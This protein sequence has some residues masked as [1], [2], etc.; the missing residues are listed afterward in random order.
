MDYQILPLDVSG[1]QTTQPSCQLHQDRKCD[2][3]HNT[4]VLYVGLLSTIPYQ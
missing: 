3:V 2:F 4:N 1:T